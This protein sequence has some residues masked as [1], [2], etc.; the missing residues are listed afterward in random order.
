[1]PTRRRLSRRLVELKSD[2]PVEHTLDTLAVRAP[3]AKELIGFLKTMEFTTLMRRIA[4][5]LDADVSQI[6]PLPVEITGWEGAQA[7]AAE[8]A[9]LNLGGPDTA[10]HA[11]A[12]KAQESVSPA[13]ALDT[14]RALVRTPIDLSRYETIID[15]TALDR[16][17]LDIREQG[18]VAIDTETTSLDA[19]QCGLVGI[20]L[21]IA[22]GRAC[23]IPVA[24]RK[25]DGLDFGGEAIMQLPRQL[26]LDAIRPVLEDPAILKIGH[27]VKYDIQVLGRCGHNP[28]PCDDTLLMSYAMESGLNGHGM[29]ELSEKHL[30]HKPISFKDVAGSGRSQVTFDLVPVDRATHY[31]AEDADVTLRLWMLFGPIS[32]P[33]RRQPSMRL[34]SGRYHPCLPKLK[35]TACS[36]TGRCWRGFPL[37]LPRLPLNWRKRFLPFPASASTSARRNSSA[38]FCSAAW[39]FRAAAKPRP[40]P[41]APMPARSRTLAVEGVEFAK[42]VLQWRQL[43]KLRSTYTDALCG[44]HP[45][46]N[47]PRAHLLRHGLDLDRQAGLGRSQSAEHS[48]PHR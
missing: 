15:E 11:V 7:A 18:F 34:S 37:N 25:G 16:W 12:A 20:S 8:Q 39:G 48:D 10:P 22:P 45:S 29:D 2:V 32:S 21:A 3:D 44:F 38:I 23:Y 35:S 46:R 31:A 36:S 40:V 14:L 13:T 27:N 42:K 5:S 26:V 1:M 6:D 17:L 28:K 24:H 47:R 41:G 4:A 30:G 9:A 43:T 33:G 19:M